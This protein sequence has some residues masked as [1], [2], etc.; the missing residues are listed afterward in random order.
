MSSSPSP[1]PPLALIIR[2]AEGLAVPDLPLTVLSPASTTPL[3][4]LHN[5]IRPHLPST[6]SSCPI[7]LISSGAPLP[8][9]TPLSKSLRLHSA[10]PRSKPD[11]KGKGK[12]R[13]TSSP[14]RPS[15]SDNPIY[16]LCHISTIQTLSPTALALEAEAAATAISATPPQTS[17]TSSSP[18]QQR[19]NQW[20]SQQQQQE[21][22]G[23]DRLLSAGL[24]PSEISALRSQFLA[25]TA[26]AHTPDTMP[27]PQQ[28]RRLE[29]RWLD[30]SGP[31]TS[32]LSSTG[33]G[34]GA[35][36]DDG[37]GGGGGGGIVDD[38]DDDGGGALSDMLWGNLTGFFWPVGAAVWLCREDGVWSRR[39]Q[40]AVVTG[41]LVNLSFGLMRMGGG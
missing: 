1:Y 5:D 41:V 13:E 33:A 26:H 15:S 20:P 31:A 30:S 17:P 32:R 36:D 23:F 14:S 12:E 37:A 19:Q 28:M 11:V 24:T 21:P 16:I 9:S 2:F 10:P 22:Q 38:D 40:V 29:E 3:H 39:R 27:S 18:Q 6:Y 4:L 34:A 7:R 25:Q 8:P 35:D